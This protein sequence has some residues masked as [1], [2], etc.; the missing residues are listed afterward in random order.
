MN[1]TTLLEEI[2]DIEEH[3]Y[4]L[5]WRCENTINNSELKKLHKTMKS[6]NKTRLKLSKKLSVDKD[7]HE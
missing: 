3:I 6:L 1:K 7:N 2:K 4:H 5:Q